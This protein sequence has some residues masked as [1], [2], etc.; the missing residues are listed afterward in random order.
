[1]TITFFAIKL[2]ILVVFGKVFSFYILIL[3]GDTLKIFVSNII[4]DRRRV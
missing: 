3:T 2:H 1:M 4:Q